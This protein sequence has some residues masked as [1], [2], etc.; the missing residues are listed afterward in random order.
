MDSEYRHCPF[1]VRLNR[2]PYLVIP[3]LA[4]QSMPMEWRLRF[5]ALIQE[6]QDAGI[7]TPEYFVFRG[8]HDAYTRAKIV[9]ENTGFVRLV[10]GLEDPW[11]D[12]RH[13]NI[14]DLCPRMEKVNG[15]M[16]QRGCR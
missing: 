1:D 14:Y 7:E 12:Y 3:K 9:N 15:Q 8:G 4:L 16:T 5:D 11:A 13:G 2:T 10:K 6:A